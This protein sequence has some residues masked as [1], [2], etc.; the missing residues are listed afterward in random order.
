[1]AII[2]VAVAVVSLVNAFN[3]GGNPPWL[4]IINFI[5]AVCGVVCIFF[6]AK[7]N[8]SN[9]AFGIINTVVYII[10]LIYWRVYATLALEVI[11]YFPMN[12]ISWVIWAR[13][14]DK[15]DMSLTLSKRMT[16]AQ[17]VWTTIAIIGTTIL[18]HYALSTLAGSSWA[19][20]GEAWNLRWLFTWLDSAT[21][22]IGIVA[23][24]LECFRY[25]EQYVWWLI[26][27]IIA[28]ALYA[29]KTPF[30]PVYF[31]KKT[32]YLIMAIVGLI[33]WIKLNKTRNSANE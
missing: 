24:V 27:D 21:F 15:E 13:H 20:I 1:M 8:I 17:K 5:S 18:T 25:A 22:A 28:V 2:M 26:T 9:F 30:D 16:L 33:N 14:K 6:C 31:T 29:I 7:A 3:G 19:N 23:V 32:I 12:I 10:Y 4:A 11:V